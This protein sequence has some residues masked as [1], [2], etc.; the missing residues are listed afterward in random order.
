MNEKRARLRV[1]EGP[2]AQPVKQRV[3]IRR[4]KNFGQRVVV[5]LRPDAGGHRQQMQVVVAEQG[6]CAAAERPDEAQRIERP[7]PA[8]D[9]VTDEEQA[10]RDRQS[11]EQLLQ[12]VQATLHVADDPQRLFGRAHTPRTFA[13]SALVERSNSNGIATV[14]A[15]HD[16]ASCAS[17]TIAMS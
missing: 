8:V 17:G 14:R 3:A 15:P 5:V 6:D 13:S 16:R 9:Q 2:R 1:G 11:F 10:R 4:S 12:A 7:W